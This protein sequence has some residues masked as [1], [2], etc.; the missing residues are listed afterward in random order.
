MKTYYR[1]LSQLKPV[2]SSLSCMYCMKM[3]DTVITN[4]A[5]CQPHTKS[6]WSVCKK[7]LHNEYTY[8]NSHNLGVF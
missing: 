2:L 8:L 7:Y 3:N 1:S 5:D 6:K 4:S